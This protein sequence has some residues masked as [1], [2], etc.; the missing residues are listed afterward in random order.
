MDELRKN[1]RVE[2]AERAEE[3]NAVSRS[4]E[5]ERAH[6]AEAERLRRD[7]PW[8]RPPDAAPGGAPE[9]ISATPEDGGH[10]VLFTPAQLGELRERWTKAQTHFVD[11]PRRAVEDAD[12]L[13]AETVKHLAESFAAERTGLEGQWARGD[14]VSTEDL[15][16]I[17]RRYRSFFDRLLSV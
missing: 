4:R 9:R 5:V 17:L 7:E 3:A 16:Q 14:Q 15:R 10:D 13:V 8:R 12:H 11:E 2:Q 1:P 6:E